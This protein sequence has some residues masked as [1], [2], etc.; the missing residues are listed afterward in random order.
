[1]WVALVVGLTAGAVL[2]NARF[3]IISR[4]RPA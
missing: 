3:W 1:V 4:P 2:L